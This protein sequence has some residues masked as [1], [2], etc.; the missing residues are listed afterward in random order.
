MTAQFVY[1][2]QLRNSVLQVRPRRL[3]PLRRPLLIIHLVALNPLR[4]TQVRNPSHLL[5]HVHIRRWKKKR[6]NYYKRKI[7]TLFLS[8]FFFVPSWKIKKTVLWNWEVRF[9]FCFLCLIAQVTQLMARRPMD[10]S[11]C[12]CYV[13]WWKTERH[14]ARRFSL[15]LGC[16]VHRRYNGEY[17]QM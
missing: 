8:F 17:F 12:E 13:L 15:F 5:G 11:F 10:P 9:C 14:L 2:A 1:G 4:L 16:F 6:V 7:R 3:T